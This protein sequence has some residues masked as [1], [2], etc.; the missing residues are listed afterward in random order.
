MKKTVK[1]VCI[2]A[3][4]L[5]LALQPATA[6]QAS[7]KSDIDNV[8]KNYKKGKIS[9]AKKYNKKLSKKASKACIKKL[10][11][12]AKKA[13]LK[14]VKKYVFNGP[15]SSMKSL[16]GYYLADMDGDKKAEL[17]V[18]HGTCEADVKITVYKYKSGK[19]KKVGSFYSGHTTYYAYPGH[20]GVIAVTGHMG[21]ESVQTITLKGGKLKT[22]SYGSRD[23]NRSGGQ[24]WFPFRQ[25]LDN[26]VRYDSR[27][28]SS[29]SLKDLK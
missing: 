5:V 20:A 28:R 6:V 16:W 17:L 21:Y 14:A 23:L 19:A 25:Q 24:D 11:K 1:K 9:K 27:Y 3:L 2:L 7:A 13:Y 10:S 8:L 29:L 18:K 15:S 22:K 4:A 26:H 12:K